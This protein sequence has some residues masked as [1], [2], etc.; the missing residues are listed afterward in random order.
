ME[1]GALQDKSLGEISS[2]YVACRITG[3][4]ESPTP[5][6]E[7]FME[8][9]GVQGYPTLLFLS[10][11]G[12]LVTSEVGRSPGEIVATA[13]EASRKE[14]DFQG[15]VKAVAKYDDPA[16][17]TNLT[18]EYLDRRQFAQALPLLRKAAE[19]EGTAA[20]WM[21]LA[22]AESQSGDP[23]AALATYDRCLG[24]LG[25]AGPDAIACRIAR[26]RCQAGSG[27]GAGAQAALVE[28]VNKAKEAGDEAGRKAYA[29]AA[30]EMLLSQAG[31]LWNRG[32]QAG[33]TKILEQLAS[34]YK[35]TPQGEH[36]ARILPQIKGG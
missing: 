11:D 21:A 16:L 7:K 18:Q 22:A 25:S 36:A 12:G 14:R 26:A 28:L 35:D 23:A 27:D 29:G 32:D 9:Y 13:A 31:E 4:T 20:R 8:K 5:G 30:A 24:T 3:G 15:F 2:K 33:A 1:R 6:H 10:A 34:D 17:W 19:K